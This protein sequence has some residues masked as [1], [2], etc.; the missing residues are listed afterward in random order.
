MI[1][2]LLHPPM[3]FMLTGLSVSFG[4]WLI[5][6]AFKRD[7]LGIQIIGGMFLYGLLCAFILG[8]MM[9]PYFPC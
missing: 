2:C 9:T 8:A 5:Y 6:A 3:I 4:T 1:E 7:I